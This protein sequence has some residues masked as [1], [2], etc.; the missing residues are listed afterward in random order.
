[1]NDLRPDMFDPEFL[2]EHIRRDTKFDADLLEKIIAEWKRY[3]ATGLEPE[4]ISDIIKLCG[5]YNKAGLDARFVQACIDVAESGLTTDRLRELAEADRDGRLVVLP[6]KV[7][8]LQKMLD[9][10]TSGSSVDA[11]ETY[12]TGYLYGWKN[13]RAELLRYI[14]GMSD[15]GTREAAEAALRGEEHAKP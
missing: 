1:M 3:K 15:G 9:G 8:H 11:G 4:E 6:C 7:E 12:T 14:L 13:G 2:L 5:D 10:L